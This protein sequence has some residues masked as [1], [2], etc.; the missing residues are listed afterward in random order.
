MGLA[1]AAELNGY[2]GPLH[3]F[4]LSKELSLDKAQRERIEKLFA[5]M[6]AETIPLG[7]RLIALEAALDHRFASRSI[8]Q[9]SLAATTNKIGDVQGSLRAAHLK[10]HLLTFDI[11]TRE[12]TARYSTL[13][14][15]TRSRHDGS[16]H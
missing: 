14:G 7:E 15:Y 9:A 5:S 2:P 6:K 4:E 16:K 12:Q 8:T 10:Y 3:V 11:L 13:R 1:L